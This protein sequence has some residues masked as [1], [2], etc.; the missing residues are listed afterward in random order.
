MLY[1]VYRAE[2]VSLM[3][4]G[5]KA[6]FSVVFRVLGD[7]GVLCLLVVLHCHLGR[8]HKECPEGRQQVIS[9]MVP[10]LLFVTATAVQAKSSRVAIVDRSGSPPNFWSPFP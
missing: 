4:R 3:R 7:G 10:L 5:M 1:V 6:R 8:M 9:V 2:V